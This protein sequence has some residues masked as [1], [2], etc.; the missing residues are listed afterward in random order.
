MLAC[1]YIL[2]LKFEIDSHEFVP[3]ACDLGRI[4]S[5]IRNHPATENFPR[6]G[7]SYGCIRSW[8]W[9]QF[10]NF[11]SACDCSHT[12]PVTSQEVTMHFLFSFKHTVSTGFFICDVF[13]TGLWSFSYNNLFLKKFLSWYKRYDIS[14]HIHATYILPWKHISLWS[15]AVSSKRNKLNVLFLYDSK[16]IKIW[17]EI[18]VWTSRGVLGRTLDLNHGYFWL[19]TCLL[20]GPVI[21]HSDNLCGIVQLFKQIGLDAVD[22]WLSCDWLFYGFVMMEL[23]YYRRNL[24][25]GTWMHNMNLLECLCS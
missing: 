5:S 23:R 3:S 25:G 9:D 22:A 13:E 7:I 21:W 16:I 24:V 18:V 20:W 1:K 14:F 8:K 11:F 12:L 2:H 15:S 17:K 4:P 19:V 10:C 6:S